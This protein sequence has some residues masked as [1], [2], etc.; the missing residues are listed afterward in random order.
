[1]K[2]VYQSTGIS[3][4]AVF[5]ALHRLSVD[6]ADGGEPNMDHTSAF[7]LLHKLFPH[8]AVKLLALPQDVYGHLY[9]RTNQVDLIGP[10]GSLV[11][12]RFPMEGYCEPKYLTQYTRDEVSRRPVPLGRTCSGELV[13]AWALAE[14]VTS[15]RCA[16]CTDVGRRSWT[17]TRR[18]EIPSSRG[19]CL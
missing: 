12:I 8:D 16:S 5:D 19:C 7:V 2:E 15:V 1:M 3:R 10:I 11:V 18:P 9:R 4:G 13:D 6:G 17:S 14:G